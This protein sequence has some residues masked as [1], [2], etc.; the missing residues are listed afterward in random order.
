ML[1]NPPQMDLRER[2][3]LATADRFRVVRGQIKSRDR[4]RDLAEVYTHE[5]EVKAML[6]LVGSMFPS[7]EEPDKL[8]RTFLEPACGDGNFLVE[9]LHRK[10]RHVTARCHGRG[11]RFEH[12][13]L[14]CLASIYGIDISR[15]NVEEAR[16]RMSSMI[17]AH[18]YTEL[19]GAGPTAGFISATEAILHSN[20]TIGDS[21]GGKVDIELVEYQPRAGGTFLRT[22]SR[23]D[24]AGNEPGVQPLVRHRDTAPLHYSELAETPGP[25]RAEDADEKA[26]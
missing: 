25:A 16:E 23:L 6:D 19:G 4:V 26:A 7:S 18:M 21:L 13:V 17:E 1:P 8:D 14:R 11:E 5:R 15:D 12:R 9:I 24:L 22:W 20:V 2:E 3:T 10:L